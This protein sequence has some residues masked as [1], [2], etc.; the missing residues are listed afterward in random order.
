M[1]DFNSNTDELEHRMEI[2]DARLEV[3]E[4]FGFQVAFLSCG[5]VGCALGS[6][7]WILVG[8]PLYFIIR[9]PYLKRQE[10][11]EKNWADSI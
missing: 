7:W 2:E 9:R 6:Y 10:V 5:W 4:E 1:I 11:A 8:V 3:V